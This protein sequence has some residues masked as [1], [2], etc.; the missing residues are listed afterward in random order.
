MPKITI[1]GKEITVEPGTTVLQAAKA[2][3]IEIPYFCWHPKLSIDGS[4]RMCQVEVEKIPKLQIACN[5]PAVDGMIVHT[6][7]E[8]IQRARAAVMELLLINH[9]LDCPICDEAGECKLQ[10]LTFSYGVPH[11]RYEEPKRQL[12]KRVEIGPR[13]L[14]D[15]ERCI[16]CRR[17]VRFCREIPKTGELVVEGRADFSVITTFPG[18]RLDNRYSIN[19]VD[20][21]PV[22]ALTSRDFRFKV[23]VWFLKDTPSVCAGCANGCNMN[24]AEYKDRIYRFVP[25]RN[26]AVNDTWMC[27]DG[28]LSYK[29]IQAPDRIRLPR[30]R[31]DLPGDPAVVQVD[32]PWDLAIQTAARRLED[33]RGAAESAR[34]G[35]V[36]SAHATNED[37][38][39]FRKFCREL[40]GVDRPAM[41]VPLW[42]PD[43]LLIKPERAANGA[44]A[45]ALGVGGAEEARDLLA[46]CGRGEVDALVVLGS[47]LLRVD[48][49]GAPL[50]PAEGAPAGC[51]RVLAALA[52]VGTLIAI[53][54]HESAISAIAH[55]VL[56]AQSFAEKDGTL[57]N[58][59]GRVQRIRPAIRPVGEARAEWEI[60]SLLAAR[61]GHAFPYRSAAEILKEIG[62][63][64]AAFQGVTRESVG[65]S[66]IALTSAGSR[67]GA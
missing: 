32:A 34:F 7:T 46:R 47:D 63:E 35:A 11:S 12:Q 24:I 57:T 5:T 40:L 6:G 56:P 31:A 62:N 13:V 54:S 19:T 49:P 44:G 53:D 55:V 28:R 42:E 10:D 33:A 22:G 65:S 16:L 30:L 20:I 9:P 8:R 41:V 59:K 37:L 29:R 43:D 1:D 36:A 23:R 58:W 66:G 18:R 2:H 67:E 50:D 14:L 4:C 26:D 25:R 38:F 64:V 3:G 39:V 21:C 48:D 52:R 60:V 17:C 27:D 51:D 61:M 15:E 45:R